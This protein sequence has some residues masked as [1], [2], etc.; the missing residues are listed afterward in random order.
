MYN[1]T[2][3]QLIVILISGT[4]LVLTL[5]VGEVETLTSLIGIIIFYCIPTAL[6]CYTIGWINQNKKKDK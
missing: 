6:I 4:L 3:G 1:I 5:M 2:K